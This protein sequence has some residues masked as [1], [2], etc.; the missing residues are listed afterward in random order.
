V[1]LI[2]TWPYN[3]PTTVLDYE[4]LHKSYAQKVSTKDTEPLK[5]SEQDKKNLTELPILMYHHVGELPENSD[6]IRRDLT[7]STTDFERE[8]KW[9][10]DQGYHSVSL[11]EIYE[12]VVNK[13]SL[14]AKPIVFTFDD[15]YDDTLVNAPAILKKYNYTASF[16]IITGFVGSLGYASWSQISAAKN[17]EMEIV[18]H[19]QN[20]FD[21]S[22]SKYS[23]NYIKENLLA[24]QNDIYA[25]LGINTNILIYP[26]GHYTNQYVE[27]AKQ[28][29][30][31]MGLT[32]HFGRFINLNDLMELPRVRVHG[33][34]TMNKFI[35]NLTKN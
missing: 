4:T 1:A 28:D 8:V 3:S 11:N 33:N 2:F 12:S 9:L 32:V 29:G 24:S 18:S 16:A 22:S 35:E 21:G 34:E 6:A 23:F 19:T 31:V 26:Y 17:M 27:A 15:G 30:F 13:K 10:S 14:P 20:H 25:N 5:I 7:V